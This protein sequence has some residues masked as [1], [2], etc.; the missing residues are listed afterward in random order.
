MLK[1]RT[2][3][4][5]T[6]S[7]GKLTQAGVEAIQG[8]LDA[9]A[10]AVGLTALDGRVTAVETE[11]AGSLINRQAAQTAT[12]S[13]TEFDFT[14]IPSWVNRVTAI[15]ISLSTSGTSNPILRV[16]DGAVVS[17]GYLG[18]ASLLPNGAAIQGA[19]STAGCLV[20]VNVGASSVY[21]FSCRI[22]RLTGNTWAFSGTGSFSSSATTIVFA[23]EITLT[24]ALDRVRLT[25]VGGT[26]TFDAGSVSISWE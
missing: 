18:A 5:Y 11:L 14:G 7:N 3:V 13:E 9:K 15:G 22:D 4:A 19:N 17:A 8:Q 20:A 16:G 21:R 6:A 12:G 2:D 25:T 10:S 23:S 26:D 1:L 24:N